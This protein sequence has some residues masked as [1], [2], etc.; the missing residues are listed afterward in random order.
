MSA[1]DAPN[2]QFDSDMAGQ[3][4]QRSAKVAELRARGVNPYAND[5]RVTHRI[6][7]VPRDPEKLPHEPDIAADATLY[8]VAGRLI[9][10]TEKGK[11]AFL[12]LRG[13]HGEMI[14]LFVKI[15]FA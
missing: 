6:A 14:Q 11:V 5:F 1:P 10:K 15:N 9:Q 2:Q 7:D 12:F 4:A 13:D 8:S 3:M